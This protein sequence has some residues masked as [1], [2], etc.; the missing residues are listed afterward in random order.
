MRSAVP[1]VQN[2]EFQNSDLQR[3]DDQVKILNLEIFG[4]GSGVG[5]QREQLQAHVAQCDYRTVICQKCQQSLVFETLS[6]HLQDECPQ[7][8][9]P[10]S[11]R[12]GC[13]ALVKRCKLPNH[14]DECMRKVLTCPVPGCVEELERGDMQEHM[15]TAQIQH[16]ALF[17]DELTRA[18][19][20]ADSLVDERLAAAAE[21]NAK[22]RDQLAE[23]RREQEETAGALRAQ[24]AAQEQAVQQLSA[25]QQEARLEEKKA[26]SAELA[27]LKQGL[28]AL[29]AQVDGLLASQAEGDEQLMK[30]F[31]AQVETVQ[32]LEAR[33]E[34]LGGRVTAADARLASVE[35]MELEPR[36]S[37]LT[38][39]A[40]AVDVEAQRVREAGGTVE[41]RLAMLDSWLGATDAR[42]ERA[43]ASSEA[44]REKLEELSSLVTRANGRLEAVEAMAPQMEVGSARLDATEARVAAMEEAAG[45]LQALEGQ[46]A[47]L[48]EQVQRNE[49]H[50]AD[51]SSQLQGMATQLKGALSLLQNTHMAA[52]DT[53]ESLADAQGQL[54]ETAAA[55]A[56]LRAAVAELRAA[57]AEL[58][59]EL[60]AAVA[61]L[62]AAVAEHSS[63]LAEGGGVQQARLLVEGAQAQLEEHD[64][65]LARLD[66]SVH[67]LAS[68]MD[69]SESEAAG[70]VA[71]L[72][73]RVV[74]L[75]HRLADTLLGMKAL[76]TELTSNMADIRRTAQALEEEVKVTCVEQLSTVAQRLVGEVARL[77]Q[78]FDAKLVAS[79]KGV[80]D[81]AQRRQV[82]VNSKL[83]EQRKS[84]VRVL[85]RLEA[86]HKE[87]NE[88]RDIMGDA[89]AGM[90]VDVHATKGELASLR[91]D[92]L[93][94][95]RGRLET[96][97]AQLVTLE[98]T[99]QARSAHLDSVHVDVMAL[100]AGCADPM[101]RSQVTWMVTD[102]TA[103]RNDKSNPRI[104]SPVFQARGY[105]FNI[106]LV[107]N[108]DNGEDAGWLS[109]YMC[110][111]SG[112]YDGLVVWPFM[113]DYSLAVVEQVPK[114]GR[115]VSLTVK[116]CDDPDDK[117]FFN[118]LY[119]PPPG[120]IRSWGFPRLAR[121]DELLAGSFIKE[122]RIVFQLTMH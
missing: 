56:E 99:L 4:L 21:E 115:S 111:L 9:V 109:L 52:Q 102:I 34:A 86:L 8:E 98:G 110:L 120:N 22:L 36:L 117:A 119:R 100:R 74:S 26:S 35:A 93:G 79:E 5:M 53:R 49:E 65:Q 20:D 33:L 84:Y 68:V 72:R 92:E 106:H 48:K 104:L 101:L 29:R 14:A 45:R 97:A 42:M 30:A 122:D 3:S 11:Y 80:E 62:R 39:R 67:A 76:H 103:K 57:V 105:T 113:T 60:P 54:Q 18:R 69:T 13:G 40:D 6:A 58:P 15:L 90:H 108:G 78:A 28:A 43:D 47:P 121:W 107:C 70:R 24:L 96:V 114:G 83:D 73:A 19:A 23:L 75:E 61:E 41:S 116:P 37:A 82:D 32:A 27:I 25:A 77:E 87:M 50:V 64:A 31:L 46:V 55:V 16:M 2:Q 71:A 89:L 59:G 17:A 66:A 88:M 118:N 12:G 10:C 94:A 7:T 112:D 51:A 85:G 95:V 38:Q 1:A 63:Q 44:L 81:L 91:L